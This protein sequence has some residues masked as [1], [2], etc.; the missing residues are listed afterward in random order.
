LGREREIGIEGWDEA[1]GGLVLYRLFGFLLGTS[2]T[3]AGVYYYVLDEYKVSN[4]L[5]TEDIFVSKHLNLFE[6]RED[7]TSM[8]HLI[9]QGRVHC[10]Q[11]EQ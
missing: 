10:I 7:S 1:N 3:G 4:E 6:T 8:T 2:L 9:A 11:M 5:L